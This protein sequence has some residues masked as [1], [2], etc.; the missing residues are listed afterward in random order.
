MFSVVRRWH[1]VP[2]KN[3]SPASDAKEF[4]VSGVFAASIAIPMSP[5]FVLRDIV[6]LALTSIVIFG[7]AGLLSLGDGGADGLSAALSFLPPSSVR[8]AMAYAPPPAATTTASAAAMTAL[9][10]LALL[11]FSA[12]RCCCRSNFS[13]ASWRRRCSLLTTGSSPRVFVGPVEGAAEAVLGTKSYERLTSP[14]RYMGYLWNEER[15]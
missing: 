3:F 4:T 10:R 15:R 1:F 5:S 2:S 11:R 12:R 9:R 14:V 6:Y 7:P 13:L 8:P